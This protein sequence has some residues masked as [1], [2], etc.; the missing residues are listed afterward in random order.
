MK[1]HPMKDL[2]KVTN[3]GGNGTL[4]VLKKL[5]IEPYRKIIGPG[6]KRTERFYTHG[7]YLKVQE[8]RAAMDADKAEPVEQLAQ[9]I[10]PPAPPSTPQDD[11]LVARFNEEFDKRTTHSA[12]AYDAT[13]PA[14][15]SLLMFQVRQVMSRLDQLAASMAEKHH[16][17]ERVRETLDAIL[18]EV[19]RPNGH[20]MSKL[21]SNPDDRP[22]AR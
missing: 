14:Q 22:R 18:D 10:E 1:L 5:G 6:G 16:L 20:D 19:T 9:V 2:V 3:R 15:M 11:E 17:N 13:V 7:D 21:L 8:W 12:E 4:A